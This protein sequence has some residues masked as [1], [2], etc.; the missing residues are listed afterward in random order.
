[1]ADVRA[2]PHAEELYLAFAGFP[3]AGDAERER[4]ALER[5]SDV[6]RLVERIGAPTATTE[7][8]AGRLLNALGRFEESSRASRVGIAIAPRSH[9]LRINASYA[10]F[11][12]G[13]LDEAREHLEVATDLRPNYAHLFENLMWIEIAARRFDVAAALIRDAEPGL[14]PKEPTWLDYWSGVVASYAALDAH[15]AGDDEACARLVETA[16]THFEAVT[17]RITDENGYVTDTAARIALALGDDHPSEL[18]EA[19][20]DSLSESPEN[21][22][23]HQMFLRHLPGTL[24]ADG[25]AAVKHALESLD[26]RGAN[27]SSR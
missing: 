3:D 13:R 26:P 14:D 8:I 6:I 21:W 9:V 1:E 12:L 4:V 25:T 16:L 22:W 24:D 19:L 23:R 27:P 2:I 7:H 5:Y 18:L 17:S 10:A 15:A 11:A 20:A